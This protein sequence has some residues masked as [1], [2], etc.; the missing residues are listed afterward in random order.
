M[1][2]E[3]LSKHVVFIA[4][5]HVHRDNLDNLITVSS[6]QS[7]STFVCVTPLMMTGVD[8]VCVGLMAH[9]SERVVL[10]CATRTL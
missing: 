9:R 2:N 10:V 4:M 3:Q 7:N 6:R 8:H 5:Q 1:K